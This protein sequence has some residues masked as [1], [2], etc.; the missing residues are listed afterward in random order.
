M[1]GRVVD[2]AVVPGDGS[3]FYVG[4]ATGG[5]W[6]TVNHGTSFEPV[7][8]GIG[9]TRIGA[10]AVH[11]ETRRLWVGTGEANASRSSYAGSGVFVSDDGG[12]V[13]RKAGLE[14]VRH[15]ARIVLHPTDPGT[16]WV[17]AMGPLY[18][19]NEVG[20]VYMTRDG[21]ASWKR[22]L[23]VAGTH[24]D[25][26]A[27]D[28][29]VDPRDPQHLWAA[30]WDRTRRAWNFEEAGMGSGVWESV[31]G[32]ATWKAVADGLPDSAVRGR[33]GLALHGATGTVV[34]LV[35]NQ[36]RGEEDEDE[37]GGLRKEDF[38]ALDQAG[39]AQLD[40]AKLATFLKD[41]GFPEEDSAAS[42]F[43]RV[44]S[45]DL[46]PRDLHDWL[47]DGNRAMFETPVVGAEVYRLAGRRW[48][49]AHAEPLRDVCYTYGYYFGLVE[50]DPN[51]PQHLFIAGVPLLESKDG[52]ATWR[53]AYGDNVHVDHHV[54][55]ISASRPGH[56]ISGNDGG[57]NVSWDGG[58][59]WTSANSPAV[60]QF[61]TVEVDDATPYRIYG[62]L[63]D[64]G[65]WVGPS[66]YEPSPGWL[67]EGRYPW[68]RL[69]GGDGMQVEVDRRTNDVAIV[70]SQFGYAERLDR[71]TG[72]RLDLHPLHALGEPPL[73]WNWQTP[74]WM[75]RHAPDV[76]Y[77]ASNKV[78]RSLDSGTTWETLS[79]DLTG[80]GRT[81]DVPFGTITSLH[82]S[83]LRFGQIAVG[84]DDGRLHLSRDGGH[85]WTELPFP[86]RP[87]G[88]DARW[89]VSEVLFSAHRKDRL[90]VALN[91]H[92]LDDA[93]PHL[94]V[95]DTDGR[96]WTRLQGLPAGAINALAESADRPEML[97]VGTDFGC[98]L[99]LDGGTRWSPAHPDLPPVPVHDLVIQERENEL[100]IG[101]HGRSFYV[102]DLA[103]VLNHWKGEDPATRTFAV[104]EA[105][106]KTWNKRWGKPGWAW[107]EPKPVEATGVLFAPTG[108]TLWIDFE[109]RSIDAG[110]LL[111]GFLPFAVPLATGGDPAYPPA[112]TYPFRLRLI[113]PDG[114]T[115]RTESTL[116]LTPPKD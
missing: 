35:D 6:H 9:T 39:F 10:V 28:L 18:T 25:A 80:G 72:D 102:L 11:P 14:Q 41:N 45:G 19:K 22:V 38:L 89:W 97:A 75:S 90:Y 79:G 77:M 67:M 48:V 69:G 99:S 113:A 33:I 58:A 70:S 100:V 61:Y 115:L 85:S 5:V 112:G 47:V 30:T 44:A 76:V 60:G 49:R 93:T 40:T 59:H 43:E 64:N 81:G 57:V 91:G 1:S 42:V 84:T 66:D 106:E 83:P 116:T 62:G 103:P 23:Q 31:D 15:I 13:W 50:I 114:T 16:A 53:K 108:G 26:G 98:F 94:Y 104:L 78:H 82:E 4:Y 88:P 71:A 12:K 52:G 87:A 68:E 110:P 21:G 101:T 74:I 46:K 34:A 3:E 55:V 51:D 107:A 24:G 65:T 86:V 111:P 36:G 56:L 95:T 63:Q 96:T 37:E 54:L 17:A 73:R 27:V 32:G 92:R 105:P 8:D 109:D 7:S 29:E 2:L 20:G